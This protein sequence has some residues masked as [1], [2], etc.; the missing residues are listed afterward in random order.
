MLSEREL[1]ESVLRLQE[2]WR[3]RN[4]FVTEE[5]VWREIFSAPALT[6]L[7][8]SCVADLPFPELKPHE[9]FTDYQTR[10]E[11]Q[12]ESDKDVMQKGVRAGAV[13]RISPR[14]I[15]CWADDFLL[16]NHARGRKR[17]KTESGE[18]TAERPLKPPFPFSEVK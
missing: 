9:S 5:P 15:A 3:Q 4:P 12:W 18:T 17:R 2:R 14:M 1:R 8:A 7:H 11:R 13:L 16:S 10:L 6:V